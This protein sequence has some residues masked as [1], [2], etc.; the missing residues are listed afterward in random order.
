[1]QCRI[2]LK[3]YFHFPFYTG[4]K[5]F[6]QTIYS[7]IRFTILYMDMCVCISFAF[8]WIWAVF[9]LNDYLNV[10]C[11]YWLSS[12][13]PWDS[14]NMQSL[15]RAICHRHCFVRLANI[16]RQ[17]LTLSSRLFAFSLLT[18]IRSLAV[19]NL[20]HTVVM[21]LQVSIPIERWKENNFCP[22]I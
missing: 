3:L 13:F 4:I 1:M 6:Q 20:L 5:W 22:W 10:L 18:F 16:E 11:Y 2:H 17:L 15:I 12:C 21:P 14:D 9:N 7:S 19:A 8:N